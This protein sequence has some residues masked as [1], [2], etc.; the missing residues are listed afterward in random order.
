MSHE[1]QSVL[2]VEHDFQALCQ[3]LEGVPE[4]KRTLL[5]AKLA[6]VLC[7]HI[8]DKTLVRAAVERVKM[9][10]GNHAEVS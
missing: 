9:N 4:D 8:E 7:D 1:I 2:A 3:A 6:L 10:L 5:L